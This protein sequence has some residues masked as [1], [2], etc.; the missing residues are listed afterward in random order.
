MAAIFYV[1]SL[2]Q[3]PL[4]SGISDKP[5]HAFAY[6]GL[7]FVIARALAGGLP[8]RLSIGDVV[9]GFAIATAYGVS[10]EI[11]QYFVAG[12][13]ADVHDVYADATGA[14]IALI[15]CWAW[16]IIS[17]RSRQSAAGGRHNESHG[18]LP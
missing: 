8:P 9:V 6:M 11:H 18:L 5:A 17:L 1:S 2:H 4:P 14:A 16:G 7:A 12:R 3:A 10:D 15:A 13:S